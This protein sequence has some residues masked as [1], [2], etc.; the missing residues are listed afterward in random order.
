MMKD[1]KKV[2]FLFKKSDDYKSH[3]INGVY[4]GLS[5]PWGCDMQFFLRSK[6]TSQR[7]VGDH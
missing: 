7:G 2:R 1:T 3:F 5:N 6:R 4:G